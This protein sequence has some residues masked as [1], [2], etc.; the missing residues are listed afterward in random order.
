M[1]HFNEWLAQFQAKE[2]TDIPEEII[3]NL[4]NEFHKHKIKNATDIKKTKVKQFLKELKYN[5]YYEHLTHITNILSGQKPPS[6]SIEVEE[7]M[8]NMFRCIQEPFEKHKP[9]KRLNF[10]SYS[11]CLY[12]F[13][14]LLNLDD[15]LCNFPLLKSREKLHQQD[16]IWKKICND[17]DWQFIK[18]V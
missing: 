16:V 18:T 7:K 1:N 13:C 11:Y 9:E 17:L 8:R 5:K 4:R 3:N 10:L 14:E 6:M 2:A 12:K 15:L